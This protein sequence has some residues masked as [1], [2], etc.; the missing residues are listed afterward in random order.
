MTRPRRR[1]GW[2]VAEQ[3]IT[4]SSAQTPTARTAGPAPS[5]SPGHCERSHAILCLGGGSALVAN[6]AGV[7]PC[8]D[9]AV[10]TCCPPALPI[11]STPAR[12]PMHRPSSVPSSRLSD[13]YICIISCPTCSWCAR[14][15]DSPQRC[16]R[17]GQPIS[18]RHPSHVLDSSPPAGH[19]ALPPPKPP[20]PAPRHVGSPV[21]GSMHISPACLPAY[22]PTR[23]VICLSVSLCNS[24]SCPSRAGGSTMRPN[25]A[26][27][28]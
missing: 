25:A 27:G 8:Q 28:E 14:W 9:D 11:V 5:S 13:L 22:T 16:A 24:V 23:A 1:A 4:R 3:K 6:K 19:N 15:R 2:I 17:P 7:R 10:P 26:S 12:A 21:D 18:G 20:K